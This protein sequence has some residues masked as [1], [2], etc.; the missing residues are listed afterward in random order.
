MPLVCF[1]HN[2]GRFSARRAVSGRSD[3][4][5]LAGPGESKRGR[6]SEGTAGFDNER[7]WML[8]SQRE[9]KVK[10]R[11]PTPGQRQARNSRILERL[12]G[13]TRLVE[14]GK[15]RCY[16]EKSTIGPSRVAGP[17]SKHIQQY[18]Y[19]HM[20]LRIRRQ[21]PGRYEIGSIRRSGDA[22]PRTSMECYAVT[23]TK[24][25]GNRRNHKNKFR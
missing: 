19:K 6:G 24:R 18:N 14:A 7:Q 17:Q 12:E 16:T 9:T 4:G 11:K 5:Y 13:N 20:I 25:P 1:T 22:D 15:L 8:G 10:H 3:R 23:A 2:F 21:V